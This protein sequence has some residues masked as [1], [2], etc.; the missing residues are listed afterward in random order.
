MLFNLNKI[1]RVFRDEEAGG[2]PPPGGGGNPP[3]DPPP[4]NPPPNEPPANPPGDEVVPF[5][6]SLPDTWRSDLVN[7]LDLEGDASAKR[8]TQLERVPDFKTL[9]KNYFESQDKIREGI[10]PIGLPE[11]ATD[12]QLVEYREANG[13]PVTADDYNA[14]I[15]EGLV[16]GEV[17]TRIMGEVYK[18][19]HA[20]NVSSSTMAKLTNSML[21]ARI[22]EEDLQL[23]QDGIDTQTTQ[24]QLKETWGS[25]HQTNL[26][27]IK[28]LTNQLPE[29]VHEDF[30][31]A[32]LANG[33]ALFNSPEFLVF[34]ADIARKIN[35][36]GTV[37]PN[38][39]NPTQAITDEIKTLEAKM[40]ADPDAWHKDKD[41]QSRLMAL[42]DA[43]S[44]M[45]Q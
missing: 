42:Y 12:E 16:L 14:G 22:A 45:K 8:L 28:G 38:S 1:T 4:S 40:T 33:Q 15:D 44:N 7:A 35:P 36:A 9:T 34:M 25:D 26:N 23:N 20:E 3:A 27:M 24:R 37:V 11:N 32:R 43:E 17:D 31:N 6:N 41:S 29:S 5:Y 30:M 13:V 2:D 18:I 19:A 39:N 21:N 10:K